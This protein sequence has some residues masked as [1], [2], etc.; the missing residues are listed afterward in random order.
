M[1]AFML[2]TSLYMSLFL[3]QQ[4]ILYL[5][6]DRESGG[7][8]GRWLSKVTERR[9]GRYISHTAFLPVCLLFSSTICMLC[10]IPLKGEGHQEENV[11]AVLPVASLQPMPYL[12]C[13]SG[14]RRR[15]LCNRGTWEEEERRKKKG[16]YSVFLYIQGK[17][18]LQHVTCP[19][20]YYE[21]HE[22]RKE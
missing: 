18:L 19:I 21:I 7:G 15:K 5:K 1:Y 4:T 13:C 9:K 10:S 6:K 16:L 11:Y 14:R 3:C 20:L 8:R 12:A 2:P 17:D 22:G